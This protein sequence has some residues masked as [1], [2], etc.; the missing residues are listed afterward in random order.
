MGAAFFGIIA[1][2]AV[3][4][5]TVAGILAAPK[6]YDGKSVTLTGTI[7]TALMKPGGSIKY[8]APAHYVLDFCDGTGCMKVESRDAATAD[9][10]ARWNATGTFWIEHD[11]SKNFVGDAGLTSIAPADAAAGPSPAGAQ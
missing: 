4:G 9:T 8:P 5:E 1:Q 3:A 2:A 11:R 6:T 7:A 10:V